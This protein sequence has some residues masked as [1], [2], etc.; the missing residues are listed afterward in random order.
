MEEENTI[1]A[2]EDDENVDGCDV[3]ITDETPDEDLPEA[4][5]GVA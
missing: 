1:P 2:P 4:E 5:G 3:E